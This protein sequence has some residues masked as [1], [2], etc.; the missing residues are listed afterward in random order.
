MNKYSLLFCSDLIELK[1]RN[2]K[3]ICVVCTLKN[4]A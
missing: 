4:V 3:H 2:V 1:M